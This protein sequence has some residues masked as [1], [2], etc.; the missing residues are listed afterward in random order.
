M[1]IK[2]SLVKVINP[3]DMDNVLNPDFV[4]VPVIYTIPNKH[5]SSKEKAGNYLRKKF[6]IKNFAV[7]DF[8]NRICEHEVTE[9]E[10]K[11]YLEGEKND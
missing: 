10:L 9:N 2:Y 11:E 5:F 7:I 3:D 1:K 8:E 6:G 4:N